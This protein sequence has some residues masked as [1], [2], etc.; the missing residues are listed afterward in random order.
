MFSSRK[1]TVVVSWMILLGAIGGCGWWIKKARSSNV[2][3]SARS[4]RPVRIPKVDIPS[5]ETMQR[6]GEILA[7]VNDLPETTEQ[8]RE[9]KRELFFEKNMLVTSSREW[10]ELEIST[11][12]I[13]P[14]HKFVII[15]GVPYKAG[16]IL[17]DGRKIAAIYKNG[18]L[19]TYGNSKERINWIPPM[20]VELIK[21]SSVTF[22]R[23][24]KGATRKK[25][26]TTADK[27]VNLKKINVKNI[28]PEQALQLIREL[29]K[30]K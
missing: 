5:E 26:S 2:R 22:R 20:K 29:S 10:G 7:A 14:V 23:S 8:V 6:I 16:D 15:N 27:K 3:F 4:I 11:I 30:V 24:S 17:P 19:L 13:S 21:V 18:L 25:A 9:I 12:F 28:T 1:F